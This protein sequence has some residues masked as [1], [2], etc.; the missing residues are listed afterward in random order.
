MSRMVDDLLNLARIGRRELKREPTPL[1]RVV[2]G[3]V[4]DFKEELAGRAIEWRIKTLPTIWCDPGL[5]QQVFANLLSNAV[6]YTR[7]RARALIEVGTLDGDTTVYVRD[8]G[9]GFN[10]KYADK[11]FG[12]F[13]RLH[14]KEEFEGTG[15]G[16]A[17]V[18]RIV[19]KHGGC[20]WAEG[21]PDK[22]AVFYLSIPPAK[23][24]EV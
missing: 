11:L 17:T 23:R 16:L 6:K 15:V 18:E 7:P 5:M 22:G 20:V 14:G 10:M 24:P 1:G 2:E 9:V 3:V 8:N 21:A 13:Q 19:R 4:A 12:V